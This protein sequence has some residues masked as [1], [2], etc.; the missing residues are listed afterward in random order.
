[1]RPWIFCYQCQEWINLKTHIQNI[2]EGIKYACHLCDYH[3]TQ[4]S[5]LKSHKKRKHFWIKWIK[6]YFVLIKFPIYARKVNWFKWWML[7]NPNHLF[8]NNSSKWSTPFDKYCNFPNCSFLSIFLWRL[9]L[10]TSSVLVWLVDFLATK[11]GPSQHVISWPH[12][13]SL[14]IGDLLRVFW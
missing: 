1:M 9:Y 13:C 3:S 6:Q 14:E 4:Q 8:T 7:S 11:C 5:H 12:Y 2:H 10:E